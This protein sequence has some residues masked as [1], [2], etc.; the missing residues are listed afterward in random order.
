MEMQ[1]PEIFSFVDYRLYLTEIVEWGRSTGTFSNRDFAKR[2]GLGSPSF[3]RMIIQGKRNLSLKT[4]Q[5]ISVA[6]KLA[7]EE[8]LY[9]E[10]L[11]R[12]S[13]EVS[14]RE[15]DKILRDLLK[16]RKLKASRLMLSQEY[17]LFSK[18]YYIPIFEGLGSLWKTEGA[19]EIAAATRLSV[20]EVKEAL[21][22][23]ESLN[24]IEQKDGRWIRK[25]MALEATNPMMNIHV[26]NF[27]REMVKKG[28]EMIDSLPPESR[29]L[30]TVTI[31]VNER[32]LKDIRERLNEF[33]REINALYTS[34]DDS[35]AIY[36]L[37]FQLF[38]VAGERAQDPK[39]K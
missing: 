13:H 28:L 36:Q 7:S 20:R 33:R 18:W 32:S 38:P 19:E 22:L 21:K 25:E 29:E 1:R 4:A 34:T 12:L 26:R 31:A 5:K 37:N 6:L 24:L 35:T 14:A 15:G 3:L 9:L 30:G 11:V 2:A 27:H 16:S 10:G 8:A 17:D 39:P 23:L